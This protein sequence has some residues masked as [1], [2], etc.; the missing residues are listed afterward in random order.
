[1]VQDLDLRNSNM[2]RVGRGGG[3]RAGDRQR[4]AAELREKPSQCDVRGMFEKGRNCSNSAERTGNA[5]CAGPRGG[6]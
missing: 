3:T 1:M 2:W 4:V 6:H 5:Q